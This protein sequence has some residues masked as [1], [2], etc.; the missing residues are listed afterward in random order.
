MSC[1]RWLDKL[2]YPNGGILFNTE[3]KQAIYCSKKSHWWTLNTHYKKKKKEANFTIKL[4]GEKRKAFSLKSGAKQGC[5]LSPY[6]FNTVLEILATAVGKPKET[7]E[8]QIRKEEVKVLFT[9]DKIVCIHK[10]PKNTLLGNFISS[11]FS[12]VTRYKT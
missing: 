3:K 4:N 9:D 2:I 5:W 12:Q 11:H 7:K 8:I 1:S 10:Q 6:I